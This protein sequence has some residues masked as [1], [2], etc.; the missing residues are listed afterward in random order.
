MLHDPFLGGNVKKG[1]RGSRIKTSKMSP[2]PQSP[3]ENIRGSVYHH[4]ISN[5]KIRAVRGWILE[6]LPSFIRSYQFCLQLLHTRS[7]HLNKG[8]CPEKS[9][10]I[11]GL[12]QPVP[13]S[14]LSVSLPAKQLA[15]PCPDSS[16]KGSVLLW[17]RHLESLPLDQ[18]KSVSSCLL[19]INPG[20]LPHHWGHRINLTPSMH[21]ATQSV[22]QNISLNHIPLSPG[23]AQLHQEYSPHLEV[24]RESL[25]GHEGLKPVSPPPPLS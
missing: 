23:S 6:P 24:S 21:T 25:N 22:L 12:T 17:C 4:G 13:P 19:S 7:F 18:P 11:V 8:V 3:G 14:Q 5:W 2:K 10:N 9:L 15:P 20:F 16:R 1:G